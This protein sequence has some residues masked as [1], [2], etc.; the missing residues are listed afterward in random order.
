M[1]NIPW[2]DRADIEFPN[3]DYALTLP[4][5]LLAAGGDLSSARLVRAY[6]LGIFPWYNEGEP[7]LWWSPNPRCV[8]FPQQAHC[9]K[10]LAKLIRKGEYRVTYDQAFAEV[11]HQCGETRRHAQGTW[12]TEQLKQAYINLHQLG[13]AHSVE[14]W[15]D[16]RLIGGLYGIAMNKIFYGESMFS[17]EAN[18]SKFGF[19]TL[20]TKLQEL[21]YKLIDCQVTSNH[22]LSLG[23]CEIDRGQFESIIGAKQRFAGLPKPGNLI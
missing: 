9:S 21:D 17:L 8:V 10:S 4:N 18:A 6:S 16:E 14:V 7:I 11:I 23:A 1:V 19:I 3:T 22:L 15:Q 5:G 20:A 2:L 12:I 13:Y